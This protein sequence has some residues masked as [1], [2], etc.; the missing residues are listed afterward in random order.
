MYKFYLNNNLFILILMLS[1]RLRQ[2]YCGTTQWLLKKILLQLHNYNLVVSN[3]QSKIRQHTEVLLKP[4]CPKVIK[5][6]TKVETKYN[7]NYN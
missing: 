2:K 7:D 1:N 4:Q 3:I 5:Y 6:P